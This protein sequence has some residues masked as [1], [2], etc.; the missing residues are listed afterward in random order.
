MFLQDGMKVL[1]QLYEGKPIGIRLPLQV[2]L[3]VVEA[4]AVMRGGTAAPSY[5]NA[6]LENSMKIQVPPFINAGTK[7]SSRPKTA[8]TCAGRNSLMPYLS[9]ALNVMTTAARK[10]GRALTRD[11]GE[12]EHLQVSMKGPADFVSS[13]DKRT[14]RILI[15]ELSR[16]R[17]GYCFLVEES[18]AIEGPD[19]STASSSIRST[20]PRTSCTACPNSPSPSDSSATARS[21]PP[22]S[23]IPSPTRCSRRRRAMARS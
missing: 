13:A 7:S 2:V 10:A 11:F 9:P 19:K 4:D 15:E 6:V 18:G 3:E 17:P 5:K 1:V 22:S 20:A 8:L 21:S 14:E 23:S 12:L 16:A